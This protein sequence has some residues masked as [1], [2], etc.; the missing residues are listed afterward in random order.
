MSKY[1][2]LVV[3]NRYQIPGGEDVV[4]NNECRMLRE[5]G[6]EVFLYERSNSELKNM[7]FLQKLCLPF[8]VI[9]SFRAA[10][11]VRKLIRE[12]RID[13][14]HVHNTIL[15]ISPSVYYAALK[16][17]VPVVQ[18]VHNF[19]LL[20]PNGLFYRQG[21]ICEDCVSKGLN[22]AVKHSCYRGSRLQTLA[23][24]LSMKFHRARGIYR[25]LHYIVLT[26]FNREKLLEQKQ[27]SRDQI[28]VKPNFHIGN[29]VYQADRERKDQFVYAARLDETKGIMFL[30]K[31][32]KEK[33]ISSRLI[34]CGDGPMKED[35]QTYIR[36]NNLTAA[37]FMGQTD[38][39]QVMEIFAQSKAMI[40]PTRWYEGFPMTIA[41]AFSA[42]TPVIVPDLGNAGSIV[43]EGI[44]GWH[45]RPDDPD[46]L[47]E[48]LQKDVNINDLVCR[49]YR[50]HYTME[51]N[52]R[53][54]LEIYRK[55]AEK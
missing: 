31:A 15:L 33:G 20:C 37:E 53:E 27:I 36:D 2:V 55:A 50:L 49:E 42:G 52:Y 12:N 40:L 38:H 16:E 10:A 25:R 18:T 4:V 45:Y 8:T 17:G 35:V 22:C 41:E 54:L 39:D 21:R 6:H 28:S 26:E 47:A 1:R 23:L 43:R 7:S 29:D 11:D 3:H 34:I 9:W 13:I 48:V 44:T 5:N 46:S 24:V 30:L 14:V 32:W 51:N 19:R